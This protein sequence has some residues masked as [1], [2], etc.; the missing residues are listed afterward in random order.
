MQ[1]YFI[2]PT[3]TS[4]CEILWT[5]PKGVLAILV[6]GFNSKNDKK[7]CF[8]GGSIIMQLLILWDYTPNY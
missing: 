1:I 2:L 4:P 8:W 3:Y 7:A 6:Q 5:P